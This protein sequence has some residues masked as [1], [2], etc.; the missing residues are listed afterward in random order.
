MDLNV[1]KLKNFR[2]FSGLNG[3]DIQQ[4]IPSIF[5]KKIKSG[6]N[7]V[8]EGKK[9]D[10]LIFLLEGECSVTMALTL[11]TSLIEKDNRAK[12]V[13]KASAKDY[14]VFGEIN[15]GEEKDHTANVNAKTD[16]VIG[17]LQAKVFLEI[18]KNNPDIGYYIMK[19]VVDIMCDRFE[20]SSKTVLKLSTAISLLLER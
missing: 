2:V 13:Y 19:N 8:Q 5:T 1:E 7:I 16:C 15:I 17:I 14:P 3:E 6:T 18:C 12:E 4:F 20:Q 9:E 11:Q 10:Q